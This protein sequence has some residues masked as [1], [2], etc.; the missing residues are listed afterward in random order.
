MASKNSLFRVLKHPVDGLF[1]LVGIKSGEAIGAQIAALVT[2]FKDSDG[3]AVFPQLDADGNLPVTLEGTGQAIR[4][5]NASLTATAA[6]QD[7]TAG[8]ITLTADAIYRG[9]E[10]VCWSESEA[11]FELVHDDDGT[12]EVLNSY[13]VGPGQ[14]TIVDNSS[15]VQFQAGSSGVQELYFRAK[16]ATADEAGT[17]NAQISIRQPSVA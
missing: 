8:K 10:I 14:F 12:E 15:V 9:I 11:C 6:F 5:P 16:C 4:G 3:N 13:M 2:A 1:G 17:I 7:L